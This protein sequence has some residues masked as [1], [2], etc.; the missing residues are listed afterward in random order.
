LAT[1]EGR[2]AAADRLDDELAAWAK[3]L[4]LADAL[5]AL[6]GAGVPAEPVI[7][8]YAVD[9]V[10]Q[11]RARGFWTSVAHPIVGEVPYQGWPM[12]LSGDAGPWHHSH[13]PLLGEHTEEIL[14]KE[15]GLAADEIASLREA[16]IIGDRPLG[17]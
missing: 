8:A 10:E 5:A 12:K 14:S 4:S 15:L 17:L 9:E 16:G 7:H 11:T 6:Q 2:H 13:A 1:A 3:S